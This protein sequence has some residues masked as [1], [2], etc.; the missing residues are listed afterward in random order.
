EKERP[1][2]HGPPI[3]ADV[4]PALGESVHAAPIFK[5]QR[6]APEGKGNS[7]NDA[8]NDYHHEAADDREC[9][10]NAHPDERPEEPGA[11]AV[12]IIETGVLVES[13]QK[14]AVGEN[15]DD[16][17][18]KHEKKPERY[19]KRKAAP[20]IDVAEDEE[21]SGNDRDLHQH[22]EPLLIEPP[23]AAPQ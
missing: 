7:E 5:D 18:G 23:R 6:E 9:R 20:E 10:E 22:A 13:D 1:P 14:R 19:R 4:F 21:K 2:K 17:A 15:S 12:R 3:T 8:G 16:P 11:P